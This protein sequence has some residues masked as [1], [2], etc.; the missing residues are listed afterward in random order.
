MSVYEDK[1]TMKEVY[2]NIKFNFD[3]ITLARTAKGETNGL[4][5]IC[6]INV[7]HSILNRIRKQRKTWGLS[8]Y[9]V[10]MKA[11]SRGKHQY[12]YWDKTVMEALSFSYMM[13]MLPEFVCG[14]KDYG[15][16]I[17]Y[18]NGATHYHAKSMK[19]YPKWSEGHTPV[20]DDGFHLFYNDVY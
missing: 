8:I 18:V 4:P 17:D 10:C 1:L 13:D 16:G 20:K 15:D 6:A 11:N 12:S 3:F 19:K 9:E 14:L 2:L 5:P 7:A